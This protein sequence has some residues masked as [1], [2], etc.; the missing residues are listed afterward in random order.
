MVSSPR[1]DVAALHAEDGDVR[2]VGVVAHLRQFVELAKP[3]ITGL[4]VMM[5]AMGIWLAPVR[6][7]WLVCAGILL[8]TG[9]MVGAAN[10]LNMYLERNIDRHMVRTRERPLPS[11]RMNPRTALIF[12]LSLGV[13]GGVLLLKAGGWLTSALGLAALASYVLIYT[14]LKM[15]TPLALVIGAIP[16]AVPPLL[17]WA[18]ATGTLDAPAMVLFGVVFVWQMPHFLAIAMYR[19]SDY[20]RAGIR[21]VPV[22]R[23]DDVARLQTIIWATALVPVSILLF[24]IGAAGWVYLAV[25]LIVSLWF[26]FL[27]LPGVGP[28]QGTRWGRKVLLASLAYLP[29][30]F[31]ALVVD[32]LMGL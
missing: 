7:N 15:V 31:A 28:K 21:T 12:G 10:A 14:P 8:G 29:L 18:G 2:I 9:M 27:C 3:T 25:S 19:K 17:G 6:P 4:S 1:N 16:G 20:A 23:G 24:P 13:V 5:A 32:R 30:L 11:G 22:V 26:W